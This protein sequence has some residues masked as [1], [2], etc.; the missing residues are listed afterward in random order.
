M[1]SWLIKTGSRRCRVVQFKDCTVRVQSIGP[2][3]KRQV[4]VSLSACAENGNGAQ[5]IE[6]V[7]PECAANHLGEALISGSVG[8]M[9]EFDLQT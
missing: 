1:M 7:L 8:V 4:F 3:H 2:S 5:H 6:I 9:R